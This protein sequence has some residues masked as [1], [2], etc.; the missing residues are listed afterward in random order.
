VPCVFPFYVF[1]GS[2]WWS[3][4]WSLLCAG[5]DSLPIFCCLRPWIFHVLVLLFASQGDRPV[6]PSEQFSSVFVRSAPCSF[7]DSRVLLSLFCR[8]SS[9]PVP[10]LVFLAREGAVAR[11]APF[12]VFT[13]QFISRCLSSICASEFCW[14]R[15]FGFRAIRNAVARA[16]L[17]L[18]LPLRF[19]LSRRKLRSSS[20]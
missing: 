6:F 13:G 19:S 4:F 15:G 12:Q 9:A 20:C 18:S 16:C 1:S 7:L 8:L 2:E 17:D 11:S 14:P 10:V 5:S 3:W